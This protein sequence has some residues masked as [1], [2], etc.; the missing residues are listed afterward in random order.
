MKKQI[1]FELFMVCGIVLLIN[2][3]YGLLNLLF[4]NIG[5]Y[6][7]IIGM[8]LCC[9]QKLDKW[10]GKWKENIQNKKKS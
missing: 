3:Y 6:S 4:F 1:P 8:F 10:E 2:G 9:L 7:C 5:I